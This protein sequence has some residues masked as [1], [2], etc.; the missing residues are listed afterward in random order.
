VRRQ[1]AI[2]PRGNAVLIT[3]KI[4]GSAK[5]DP[6]IAA[7]N[8]VE[9]MSM[10]PRPRRRSISSSSSDPSA[11]SHPRARPLRR[12]FHF[13]SHR[14]QRAYATL[15]VKRR[16][17]RRQAHVHRHRDNS[18]DRPM[19]TNRIHGREVQAADA[20]FSGSTTRCSRSAT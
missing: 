19:A 17:Q 13:W 9:L 6:L 16:R 1:R 8:A 3:K 18:I 12:A 10:N 7:F 5:I 4:S 15:E 20:A 14:M 2:E 11:E